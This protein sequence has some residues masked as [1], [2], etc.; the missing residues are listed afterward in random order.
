MVQKELYCREN[1]RVLIDYADLRRVPLF[2]GVIVK[3][4][5][6]LSHLDIRLKQQMA[7]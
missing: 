7:C 2:Y 4:S 1:Q 3:V 6:L 5:E